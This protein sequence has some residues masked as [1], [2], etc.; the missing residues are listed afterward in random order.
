MTL[1]GLTSRLRYSVRVQAY[2]IGGL[3]SPSIAMKALLVT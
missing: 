1:V 3:G 2:N